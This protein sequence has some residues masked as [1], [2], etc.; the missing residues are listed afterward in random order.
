MRRLVCLFGAVVLCIGCGTDPSVPVTPSELQGEGSS[1]AL[2][3]AVRACHVR[4]IKA[5]KLYLD[6]RDEEALQDATNVLQTLES[7][8]EELATAPPSVEL[9]N[10]RH[11][12]AQCAKIL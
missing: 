7:L 12:Q 5:W 3:E 6:D 10:V 4:A 9:A 1:A 2:S 8:E 11:A